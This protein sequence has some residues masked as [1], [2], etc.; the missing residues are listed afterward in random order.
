MPRLCLIILL[1]LPCSELSAQEPFKAEY[2]EKNWRDW[3][4]PDFDYSYSN[5]IAVE[6]I[7]LREFF[8]S[9]S[10]NS[11]ERYFHYARF[12]YPDQSS[13]D[14]WS[15][16]VFQL[17]NYAN[18][19]DIDFR[20][21]EG[22]ILLY[23]ARASSIRE[24]FLDTL[25]ADPH[26]GK[27]YAFSLLFPEL[28]PGHVVELMISLDGTP[29]PYQLGFHQSF[30]I[31]RSVQRIKIASAYPLQYS[32][33][34]NVRTEEK[35]I[36]ENKFYTF[37]T[38]SCEALSPE[39]GLSTL[40]ASLPMVWIDWLDQVFYYDRE[41][42][43]QWGQVLENLFYQGALRDYAVY[44]NSLDY[45]FGLQQYYGSWIRPV[46]YFHERPTSLN[47]NQAYAEGRWRLSRSYAER[48]LR[49]EEKLDLI[50]QEN[51]VP[52]FEEAMEMVYRSQKKASESYLRFMPVYPPVFTE[53]GLLCSHYEAL[54]KYFK[55]D[56]RLALYYPQR[57]GRP[58]STYPSPWP[59]YARGIA[60][61]DDS[62]KAWSYIFPGPYLGQFLEPGQVPP[63]FKGGSAL[64]FSREDS[65]AP[66]WAPLTDPEI[67]RHG[68]KQHYNVRFDTK[69]NR[70]IVRDTLFLEGAFRSILAS[71]YLRQDSA[72]DQLSFTNHQLITNALRN[73]SIVYGKTKNLPA[74]DTI[75]LDWNMR[76]AQTLKGRAFNDRDYALPMAFSAEWQWR[77]IGIDSLVIDG[78]LADQAIDN[79][80]YSLQVSQEKTAKGA[81]ILRVKMELKKA[82]VPKEEYPYYLDWYQLLES[83][84]SLQVRII[85][86]EGS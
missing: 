79:P 9:N 42:S 43:R 12:Q 83:E 24:R 6:N 65:I 32:A 71:A 20:I 51:G 50:I 27:L 36:F 14:N 11:G 46:R 37:E 62:T 57:S 17:P 61:R 49:V 40:A 18:L 3:P 41:E 63:D 86:T 15:K 33:S 84:R 5:F 23:E 28:K 10:N 58:D 69:A 16:L 56:Y 7:V 44:R 75:V 81:T 77:F 29:L 34:K 73:D 22:E 85:K 30:P 4:R 21:W 2:W 45:E 26:S 38:N 31:A 55:K 59:A 48:W 19:K 64:L 1:A 74:S 53:Y 35:R 8:S 52:D 60:F 47:S 39:L 66:E 13:I 82:F 67:K 70:M 80:F 54:L 72:V 68:I 25:S 78:P 76:Q